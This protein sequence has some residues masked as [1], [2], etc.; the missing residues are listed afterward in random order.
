[1]LK[2]RTILLYDTF[3][4]ILVIFILLYSLINVNISKNS[5]YS[6]NETKLRG[7]I[8]NYNIDGNK[9][10]IYLREKETVIGTYY[11]D[12]ETDKEEFIKNYKLGDFIEVIGAMKLPKENTVFNL[13]NYRKYLY[14]K[15]IFYL[16]DIIDIKKIKS[17]TNIFIML[18]QNIIDYIN[19][20][21]YSKEYLKAFIIGNTKNISAQ[22]LDNYQIIG[23][24]HLFAISGMHISLLTLI[25]IYV[26]KKIN[27]CEYKR[28]LLVFVFL[29]FY[30]FLTNYSPSVLRA[31]IFFILSSINKN[32]YFNI[33]SIN[34]FYLT[35][36][37][38]LLINPYFLF[39]IGFQ[40]SFIISF[41]LILFQSL[42]NKYKPY[43]IKLFL[44]S[45]I[46]FIV[47]MPILMYHFYEINI[48][49]ILINMIYVPFITLVLFPLSLI[50]FCFPPL[51][52]I[53]S[54]LIELM[55]YVSLVISDISIGVVIFSKPNLITISIY[56][57]VITYVFYMYNKNKIFSVS[58]LI[59]LVIIHYYSSNFNNY[60]DFTMIDVRQ[61][62]ALL[63]RLPYNKGNI[64][65]DTGG[66]Y[67]VNMDSWKRRNRRYSIAKN[68]LIPYF[69]SL[70][71]REIDYLIVT[72]GH[73]DHMG[74]GINLVDNF[75][76]KNVI[77]NKA[78][79]SKIEKE[80][81]DYLSD[82]KVNHYFYQNKDILNIS[83]YKFYF[84]NPFLSSTED[85]NDS[86]LVIY[87]NFNNKSLLLTGDISAKVENK[88]INEY[89][90]NDLYILK[91]A[92][93]G[94]ITSTSES[95]LDAI[96]PKYAL[97]SVGYN[98]KF[99]H[100]D[101]LVIDRLQKRNIKIYMTSIHGSIKYKFY[102]KKTVIKICLS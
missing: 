56:Y 76:V 48:L 74:E 78:N 16:F 97:I 80:F 14:N 102:R 12:K 1:L 29:F 8:K 73:F 72:H 83:G 84:L 13:F 26:L 32:F 99:N 79:N 18:K 35:L 44:I 91:V 63:I 55:E 25:L 90:I 52:S 2:L 4:I 61:G 30:M 11:F 20:F 69:K 86:S 23:I 88:I 41:Y 100:P 39:D 101:K 10:T 75:K 15:D 42:I 21:E 50:T 33:K 87:T 37:T 93:H 92:H 40:F 77:F 49:S 68:T 6:G 27:V 71:I 64:L 57:L 70:G 22:V 34:L 67:I 51:D 85:L 3:Y 31:S 96:N 36:V 60:V 47:S 19:N 59:L 43:T 54:L 53:L 9:L 38:T 94:S 28:Y 66:R 46:S 89:N 95:F 81:I 5:R 45:C 7:F 24:T 82:K 98:N 58:Y 62:E 17:N 65:I